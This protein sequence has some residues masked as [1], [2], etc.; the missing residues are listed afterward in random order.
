MKREN[1]KSERTRPRG[2]I[3]AGYGSGAKSENGGRK[4]ESEGI[5]VQVKS[6]RRFVAHGRARLDRLI[7]PNGLDPRR[8]H[9]A[10][11]AGRQPA[12]ERSGEVLMNDGPRLR[13]S[14]SRAIGGQ[15]RRHHHHRQNLSRP[16]HPNQIYRS[17][18]C[19]PA[20]GRQAR[21]QT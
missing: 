18:Y 11:E 16:S 7:S 21:P 13:R 14:D 10:L 5:K 12:D 4:A 20:N 9:R 8:G 19:P 17:E 15:R 1:V 3:A 2:L 6:R